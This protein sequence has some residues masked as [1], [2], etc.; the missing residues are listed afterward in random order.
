[1]LIFFISEI[2]IEIS[3]TCAEITEHSCG[4]WH[5]FGLDPEIPVGPHRSPHLN[6]VTVDGGCFWGTAVTGSP[7]FLSFRF[8]RPFEKNKL[9]VNEIDSYVDLFYLE[10]NVLGSSKHVLVLNDVYYE[11]FNDSFCVFVNVVHEVKRSSVRD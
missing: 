10:G 6:L 8:N 3:I 11:F 5:A 4:F 1:M 9:V 7:G 2:V